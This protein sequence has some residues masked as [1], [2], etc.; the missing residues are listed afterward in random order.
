MQ[1]FLSS[2]LSTFAQESF[3]GM[4]LSLKRMG[5]EPKINTEVEALALEG[6]NTSMDLAKVNAWFFPLMILLIGISNVFVIYIGGKQYIDGE[7]ASIGIIAEFI[8]YVNMLTWPVAIVGWL[9]SII[10]RAEASKKESMNF[11]WKNPL[12]KTKLLNVHQ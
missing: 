11:C 12:S 10:Q 3:S 7:I 4:L 9:T 1:E 5:L 8:L 6:K 2:T